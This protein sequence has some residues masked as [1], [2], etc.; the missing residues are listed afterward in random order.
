LFQFLAD[1]FHESATAAHDEVTRLP[2]LEALRA[3]A[4]RVAIGVLTALSKAQVR[5]EDWAAATAA[6]AA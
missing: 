4:P 2:C 6:T 5:P 3:A 1:L